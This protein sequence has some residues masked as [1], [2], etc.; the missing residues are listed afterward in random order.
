MLP[1]GVR[2][3]GADGEHMHMEHKQSMVL[4]VSPAHTHWQGAFSLSSAGADR[5]S[6]TLGLRLMGEGC[7]S[8]F[9]S[10]S[11]LPLLFSLHL[12]SKF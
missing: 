2:P 11:L 5:S 1:P 12:D 10:P 8:L 7:L 4:A 9:L 3:L 6:Q